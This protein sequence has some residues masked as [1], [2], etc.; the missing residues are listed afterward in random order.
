VA[1]RS[2]ADPTLGPLWRVGDV[3]GDVTLCTVVG[4]AEVLGVECTVR[5]GS[6]GSVTGMVD[7][8]VVSTVMRGVHRTVVLGTAGVAVTLTGGTGCAETLGSVGDSATVVDVAAADVGVTA[9]DDTGAATVATTGEIGSCGS[10]NPPTPNTVIP[11]SAASPST[12]STH[13]GGGAPHRRARAATT[14]GRR[15]VATR[16][17]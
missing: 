2:G 17:L 5:V 11:I 6:D 8:V 10:C 12:T 15:D 7:A 1:V 3:V 16:G 14:V 9:V 13:S 4:A